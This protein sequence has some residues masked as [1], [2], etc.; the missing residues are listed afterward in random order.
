MSVCCLFV[1]SVDHDVGQCI[2]PPPPSSEAE[3]V[4]LEAAEPVA[5]AGHIIGLEDREV[6]YFM[7]TKKRV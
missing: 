5:G 7:E 1:H 4:E 6:N 3:A 2:P